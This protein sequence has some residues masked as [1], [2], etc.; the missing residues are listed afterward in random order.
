MSIGEAPV[1]AMAM[2]NASLRALL[3]KIAAEPPGVRR[4]EPRTLPLLSF[5]RLGRRS[6]YAG[7][8]GGTEYMATWQ[9]PCSLKT[10]PP[11]KCTVSGYSNVGD[12]VR[13]LSRYAAAREAASLEVMWLG[14]SVTACAAGPAGFLLSSY[15]KA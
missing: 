11:V 2:N 13:A 7:R 3:G 9:E 5:E 6:V 12:C 4:S 15:C 1:R 14:L 8:S 10:D